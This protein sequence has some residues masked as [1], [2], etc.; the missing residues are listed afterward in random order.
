MLVMLAVPALMPKA[1]LEGRMKGRCKRADKAPADAH[2]TRPRGGTG[3]LW[4]FL[5]RRHVL[6]PR[7]RYT[8]W[9]KASLSV[10][11]SPYTGGRSF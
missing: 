1:T 2:D 5:G 3:T 10:L 8:Q 9:G 7:D 6:T 11:K 4:V